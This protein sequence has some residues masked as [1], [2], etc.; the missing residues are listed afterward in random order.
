MT[1]APS[2]RGARAPRE[3]ASWEG[4]SGPRA[5]DTG[6]LKGNAKG[7]DTVFVT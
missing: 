2:G 3:H 1:G 5:G 7:P 4:A 6:G